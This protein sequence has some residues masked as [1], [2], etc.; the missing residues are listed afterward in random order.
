MAAHTC[1]VGESTFLLAFYRQLENE[2]AVENSSQ[3]TE[4]DG[5][6]FPHVKQ[7][8]MLF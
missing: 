3:M 8:K 1:S 5:E 7:V 2:A 4:S 6:K